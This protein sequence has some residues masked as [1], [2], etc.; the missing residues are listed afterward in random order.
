MSTLTQSIHFLLGLPLPL[1]PSIS[2]SNAILAGSLSSLHMPKQSQSLSSYPHLI[3][4]LLFHPRTCYLCTQVLKSLRLLQLH[5]YSINHFYFRF[6]NPFC[7]QHF[8]FLCVHLQSTFSKT[9]YQ[10]MT[11]LCISA[12]VAIS[13]T[14]SSKI[15]SHGTDVRI[16]TLSVSMIVKK[17][18]WAQC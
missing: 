15:S 6:V 4:H 12:V 8:Q 14:S 17:K 5:S 2:I 10:L 13:A 1:C 9:L 7:Y 18:E 16:S 11:F 3:S